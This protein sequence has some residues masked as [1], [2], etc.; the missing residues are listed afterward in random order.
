M[1]SVPLITPRTSRAGAG[2]I[3][4]ELR[5]WSP[6]LKLLLILGAQPPKNSYIGLAIQSVLTLL[7]KCFVLLRLIIHCCMVIETLLIAYYTVLV[8]N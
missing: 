6:L 8:L 4:R 2:V 1:V 3:S 5:G 7:L